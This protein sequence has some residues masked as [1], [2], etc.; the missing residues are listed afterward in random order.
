MVD[1]TF[2]RWV[3]FFFLFHILFSCVL[4]SAHA[5][6]QPRRK[7]TPSDALRGDTRTGKKDEAAGTKNPV[8]STNLALRKDAL[9][10]VINAD[11]Y[12]LG[13]GDQ[14]LI[15]LWGQVNESFPVVVSPEGLILVPTV[16]EIDVRNLTLNAAREKIK[17]EMKS[18][19]TNMDITVSLMGLR[20][21]RVQVSG[22]VMNPGSYVVS[23]VDRV[24]DVIEQAGGISDSA[25]SSQRNIQ[26]RR[27]NGQIL[28]A[29]L[30]KNIQTG[31]KLSDPLLSDGDVIFIPPVYAV[32]QI[33]GSIAKYGNYEWLP[34]ETLLDAIDLAGGL[35]FLADSSNIEISRFVN[36][37]L[38][39]TQKYDLRQSV[40]NPKNPLV[41]PVIYPNDRIFV[42]EKIKFQ[43][44][45]NVI[46]RGEVQFPGFYSIH[47]GKTRL[48]DIIKA[49]GGFSPDAAIK[50]II[51]Y[52]DIRYEGVDPEFERLR[53]TPVT[54]MND[55]E[56]SYFKS[57]SR[58][59][60]PTVQTD[61]SQ[62]FQGNTI[63]AKFDVYLKDGDIIDVARTKKTVRIIGGV[64]AP[65]IVDWIPGANYQYYVEKCR[66]YSSRANTGEIHII[67]PGT[68]SWIKVRTRTEIND[69][70][71]LFIAE[72]EPIDGWKVFRETIAFIGQL[73]TITA[74]IILIY[75]TVNT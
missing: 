60:Y 38:F 6:Y 4:P 65:G 74:T 71:I 30:L 46:I 68:A 12:Q 1:K 22:F 37:S 11:E 43:E 66:G 7:I 3:V 31:D 58:Q 75:T 50:N 10:S 32:F 45:K 29:D 18:I 41:N 70:D 67:R 55:I 13:P 27:I 63:N 64:V 17:K 28:R 53:I 8:I 34:N 54:E 20:S 25:L 49:S 44:K 39:T 5:Q 61:F 15:S 33:F 35:L 52:R 23:P 57:K 69:G 24:S 59:Y 21:F 47:E 16:K 72:K 42:R 26:V 2:S 19:Y 9:E 51:V 14:L 48:S 73:A 36:D 62:L 40:R 56:K